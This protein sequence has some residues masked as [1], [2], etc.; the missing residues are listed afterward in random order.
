MPGAHVQRVELGVLQLGESAQLLDLRLLDVS[1]RLR[2]LRVDLEALVLDLVAG[3][4]LLRADLREL[5]RQVGDEP[6]LEEP[7]VRLGLELRL[8]EVG[9]DR[10]GRGLL[11]HE[12]LLE[13]DPRV[14][15]LR[16]RRLQLPLGVERVA[17]ELRVRHL[18]QDRRG[19]DRVS[20]QHQDALDA[21]VRRRRDLEDAFRFGHERA[22]AADFAAHRSA[23]DGVHPHGALLDRGRRR[24]QPGEPERDQKSDADAR[25]GEDQPFAP[26]LLEKS[27]RTISIRGGQGRS[28]CQAT[29]PTPTS[30]K[31][32]TN[33]EERCRVARRRDAGVR[34]RTPPAGSARVLTAA[35]DSAR[36]ELVDRDASVAR[37][38]LPD[39]VDRDAVDAHRDEVV[40]G[41]VAISESLKLPDEVRTDAVDAHRDE[42]F[43]R[44]RPLSRGSDDSS[45]KPTRAKRRGCASTRGR[46]RGSG[47]IRG[48]SSRAR[49]PASRRGC[50]SRRARRKAAGHTP[51]RRAPGSTRG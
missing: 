38:D 19:S 8:V 22:R 29:R 50:A 27:S 46:R 39:E 31:Q 4:E 40:D 16:L 34:S 37:L 14:D 7:L 33:R 6:F 23:L 26:A 44:D 51:W 24:L 12:L 32:G 3:R 30:T 36:D 28:A 35:V 49:T 13:A 15:E 43:R 41:H 9:L 17:L 45:R 21:A 10:G 47:R 11:I 18:E 20:G 1:L 5:Q 25:A 2:R 48:P 42:I